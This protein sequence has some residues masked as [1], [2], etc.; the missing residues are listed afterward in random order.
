MDRRLEQHGH[1]LTETHA[2]DGERLT[3]RIDA[4]SVFVPEDQ[5][6]QVWKELL[7]TIKAD[8]HPEWLQLVRNNPNSALLRECRDRAEN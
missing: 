4:L 6:P 2:V 5:R 7:R 8:K 1:Y 3:G